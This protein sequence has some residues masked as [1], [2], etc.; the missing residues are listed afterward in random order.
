L[1]KNSNSV[2]D[3]LCAT[4]SG[5]NTGDVYGGCA[6]VAAVRSYLAVLQ[7]RAA[8]TTTWTSAI[9]NRTATFVVEPVVGSPSANPVSNTASKLARLGRTFAMARM[10]CPVLDILVGV[11]TFVPFGLYAIYRLISSVVKKPV[12]VPL[13]GPPRV[14]IQTAPVRVSS[15]Q[16]MVST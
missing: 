6:R 7:Y 13:T 4:M 9:Y 3:F 1:H 11:V 8:Q 15:Y 2:G 14:R 16:S 5:L 12:A 10:L